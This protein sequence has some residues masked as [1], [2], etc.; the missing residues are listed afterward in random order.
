LIPARS[1]SRFFFYVAR[2]DT[3]AAADYALDE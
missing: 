2:V 3:F 1:R